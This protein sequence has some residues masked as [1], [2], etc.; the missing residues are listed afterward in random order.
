MELVDIEYVWGIFV[1]DQTKRF[2]DFF[3]IGIYTSR[4]LALEELGRLPRDENYQL[5]RMPLNKSFPYYHKK[6]GKLVG[7]NAIH[8]E[9]FHYKDEQDREES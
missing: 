4:E 7:M 8:H 5:L 9:H 2:P 6:T 3:P 1:A